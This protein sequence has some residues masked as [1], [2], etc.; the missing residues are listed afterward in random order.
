[1]LEANR[2][3][4][5]RGRKELKLNSTRQREICTT[6]N[7]SDASIA[8]PARLSVSSAS[9]RVI[10]ATLKLTRAKKDLFLLRTRSRCMMFRN[11]NAPR[12]GKDRKIFSS[13]S[14][15]LHLEADSVTPA[16]Y[17]WMDVATSGGKATFRK[18][19]RGRNCPPR[20]GYRQRERIPKRGVTGLAW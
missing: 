4:F 1:M 14:H 13:K 6:T 15:R 20:G 11:Q 5:G 18:R 9:G 17:Q 8:P 16:A 19:R 2:S 3:S 10:P 7:Q 12:A